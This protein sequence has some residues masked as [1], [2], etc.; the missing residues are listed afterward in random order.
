MLSSALRLSY[1]L[2]ICAVPSVYKSGNEAQGNT[3]SEGTLE[4]S[5]STVVF[6][7]FISSS[8]KTRKAYNFAKMLQ[9]CQ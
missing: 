7:D 2:V 4:V 1:S 3:G 8:T 9:P 6:S 5:L